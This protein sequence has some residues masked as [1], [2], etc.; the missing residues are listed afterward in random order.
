MRVHANSLAHAQL[1]DEHVYD[2]SLHTHSHTYIYYYTYIHKYSNFLIWVISVGLA[3]ARP[4]HIK[5]YI[6][7]LELFFQFIQGY[8]VI[9]SFLEGPLRFLESSSGL[10]N[11]TPTTRFTLVLSVYRLS[12]TYNRECMCITGR[13]NI[14]AVKVSLKPRQHTHYVVNSPFHT[15]VLL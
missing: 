13:L 9:W 15:L 1:Y 8:V 10:V 11:Q 7:S 3:S 6:L 5:Q 2:V 14:S 4:S 12:I